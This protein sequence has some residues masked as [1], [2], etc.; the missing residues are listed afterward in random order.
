MTKLSIPDM[1]C[2][3]CKAA[4]ETALTA[5]ADA[6]TVEVDL[7]TRMARV[8]GPAPV[9]ELLAALDQAGYPASIAG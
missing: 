1:S 2:G 4:V 5:V 7:A 8:S 3:H 9:A 6:G